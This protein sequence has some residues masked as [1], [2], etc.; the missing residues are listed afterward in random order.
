ME[1]RK[2][3]GGANPTAVK[4]FTAEQIR[5][6][7]DDLR[8]Y[9]ALIRIQEVH[10][11]LLVDG[12]RLYDRGYRELNFLP[13][14]ERWQLSAIY[15]ETGAIVEWY[16]DI[17]KKNSVDEHGAPYCDDC[18]L[19]AAVMPDGRVLILDEDELRQALDCGQI[20]RQEYDSAHETLD[21][22]LA[23][24]FLTVAAM[25][26]LCARLLSRFHLSAG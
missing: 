1:R 2:Y 11:P 26:P 6:D 8:G 3:L 13:D 16:V 25:E 10:R 5:I 20:T 19:D 18:Y 23:G 24:N 17:T 15:D 12:I 7:E 9:A 21:G 14:G 4:D 22:L